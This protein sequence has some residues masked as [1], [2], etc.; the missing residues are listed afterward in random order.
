MNRVI[1]PCS[2][3]GVMTIE[4]RTTLHI[5][6][7]MT[8]RGQVETGLSLSD[9]SRENCRELLQRWTCGHFQ[10]LEQWELRCCV[11]RCI[12]SWL[13]ALLAGQLYG[14]TILWQLLYHSAD[15]RR[16]LKNIFYNTLCWMHCALKITVS[17]SDAKKLCAWKDIGQLYGMDIHFCPQ[18]P[19]ITVH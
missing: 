6:L 16:I 10:L 1:V 14:Y 18:P 13:W 15:C 19:H 7:L 5:S 9:V 17:R 11:N 12:V 2:V 3:E 8:Q 4:R